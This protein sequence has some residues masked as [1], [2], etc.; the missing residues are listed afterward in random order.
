MVL[1][2]WALWPKAELAKLIKNS[3]QQTHILIVTVSLTGLWLL[4][5]SMTPGIHVHFLGIVVLLL[6]FGWRMASLIALLPTLFFAVFVFKQPS[7][8]A[9]YALLG[10]C[11]PIFCCFLIY[12]QMF[13]YLPHHLFIYIFCGAFLNGFLSIMFHILAWSIWLTAT[14][15]YSWEFLSHN[16]LVLIPLLG[17]PEALLNG[18]AITLLVVY[19]PDWL[20]DYSD[21]TYLWKK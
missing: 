6:M 16:Y 20:Y 12:S 5:A 4:N 7:E 15:D 21:R 8:F 14:T 11:L 1:W 13:K 10:V 3:A 2:L 9:I 17:F 19:R 18:M